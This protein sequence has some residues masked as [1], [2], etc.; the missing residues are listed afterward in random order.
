MQSQKGL[1]QRELCE[2]LGLDYKTVAANAKRAGISTHE[3]VHKETGWILINELYYP[4]NT[5]PMGS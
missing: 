4:P 2:M 5:E 1:R 3:Y